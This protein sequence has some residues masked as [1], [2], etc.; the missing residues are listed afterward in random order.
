MTEP[1][2]EL[3][4][5]GEGDTAIYILARSSGEGNDRRAVQGDF[6]LT[7]TET[8]D[9][10]A[11]QKKY[12]HFMLVLNTGSVVDLSPVMEVENILLLSQLGASRGMLLQM[13]FLAGHILPVG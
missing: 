10:L 1:E 5:D 12:R 3:P 8:R 4:L 2:Y 11:C 7:K 13:C 9:I 6:R